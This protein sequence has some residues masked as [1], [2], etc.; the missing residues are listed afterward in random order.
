MFHH[1]SYV[2][3]SVNHICY[4]WYNQEKTQ[5]AHHNHKSYICLKVTQTG[6][7]IGPDAKYPQ[8]L[9]TQGKCVVKI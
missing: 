5:S 4:L 6:M 3:P 1:A 2:T 9:S 8:T 7:W